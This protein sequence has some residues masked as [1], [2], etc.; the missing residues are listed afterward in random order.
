MATANFH[1]ENDKELINNKILITGCNHIPL[2]NGIGIAVIEG[3]SI[4]IN[5]WYGFLH[6]AQRFVSAY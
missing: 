1:L 2:G 6:I 3:G 5:D 4:S